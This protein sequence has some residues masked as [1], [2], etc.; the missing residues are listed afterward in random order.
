MFEEVGF[1]GELLVLSLM[2]Y[3]IMPSELRGRGKKATDEQTDGPSQLD[4]STKE[5]SKTNVAVAASPPKGG[6][7]AIVAAEITVPVLEGS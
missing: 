5:P 4:N 1:G 7:K 2:L 3:I 6:K